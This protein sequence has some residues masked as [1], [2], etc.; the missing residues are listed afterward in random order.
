[1]TKPSRDFGLTIQAAYAHQ[2]GPDKHSE[3]GLSRPLEPI[4]PIRPL[5]AEPRHK[6][7]AFALTRCHNPLD[8]N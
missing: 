2:I 7:K 8:L 4:H 6:P 1:M 3:Q 5:L